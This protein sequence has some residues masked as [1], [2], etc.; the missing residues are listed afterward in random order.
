MNEFG[1][2]DVAIVI[3]T[4]KS[5]ALTINCLK[6]IVPELSSPGLHIRVVVVDNS[7]E[8]YAPIMAVASENGWSAW[9]TVIRSPRNGGFAFGNNIGIAHIF[10]EKPPCYVYLL[11]PDT[12]VRSG[13]IG[14][15]ARFLEKNRDAG[16][17]GSAIENPD[18][19]PW[20]IAFKFPS[21]LSE[22]SSGLQFGL[23]TRMLRRWEVAQGMRNIPEPTDWVCGASL[24][25]RTD[26]L[27]TIGGL[28]ENYFLYFEETDFC[29]RAKRAGFSTWYVPESRI[30]HIVGQSTKVTER[31]SAPKRLPIYWFESRRRYFL[32]ATGTR[33]AIYIDVIS[34][35][36]HA[37][38]QLK[39]FL[40]RRSHTAIPYFVRD[41][42]RH[43]VIWPSHR[44]LL[45][46]NC[47]R[48]PSK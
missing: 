3:V 39:R 41:L 10:S 28:D 27:T 18:G 8:D 42:I 46:I 1:L 29:L 38:G 48:P 15:L 30:M 6:S 34:I 17:A 44:R 14:T 40:L 2:I 21:V 36:A 22:L 31:T 25:I 13:A 45:P 35:L 23:A 26:V 12:E 33:S 5:A 16:I 7:S 20:P 37:I 47:Y 19:S 32:T 43:S 9:L 11:N 4:F 24:M